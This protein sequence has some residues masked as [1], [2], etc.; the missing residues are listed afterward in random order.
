MNEPTEGWSTPG[1][2]VPPPTPGYGPPPPGYGP[3]P[4]GQD[5]GY[6]GQPGWTQPGWQGWQQGQQQTWQPWSAPV[7]SPGVVPLRPLTV[8]EVLDGAVKVVRQYPRPT[9]AMSAIVAVVTTVFNL[10]ALLAEDTSSLANDATSGSSS[11]SFNTG[12]DS[13]VGGLAGVPGTVFGALG[14]LVLAGFLVAVVGKAVLGRPTTFSETWQ[15]VRPRIWALIGLAFLVGLVCAAPAVIGVILAVAMG[16]VAAP[17]LLIGVPLAIAGVVAGIYLYVRLSLSSSVLVLEKAG[18]R[19]AMRRSN[20]LVKGSWWRVCGILLLVQI[21]SSV[22]T[23][24]LTFPFLVL[25]GINAFAN[26][27]AGGFTVFLVV[28]QLGG[29][30]ATF[31]VSPFAA[32]ARSLL[33]VDRRMRAEGL[34]LTLQAAAHG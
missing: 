8:G 24:V 3:P 18:V 25:A 5:Q 21:I 4:A 20:V 33:Y 13:G 6:G 11:D 31:L 10:L 2:D 7:V 15:Q 23:G 28:A 29:G 22:L 14:G 26:P 30:L 19:A 12:F 17:L 27:D 32:G 9:L 1:G 34:D 16:V